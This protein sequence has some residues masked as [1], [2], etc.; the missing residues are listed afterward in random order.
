[1]A[2]ALVVI[3]SQ[4]F[5]IRSNTPKTDQSIRTIKILYCSLHSDT[6]CSILIGTS[7]RQ[8]YLHSD[9]HGHGGILVEPVSAEAAATVVSCKCWYGQHKELLKSNL[10]ETMSTPY[11]WL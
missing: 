1:V 9:I 11:W 2:L 4:L 6:K 8:V 3:R 5:G 10:Q 7:T